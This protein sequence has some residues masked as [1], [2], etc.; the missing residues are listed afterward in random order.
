MKETREFLKKEILTPV[1]ALVETL[2]WMVKTATLQSLRMVLWSA[3]YFL[4]L[5]GGFLFAFHLVTAKIRRDAE[6]LK[7][8]QVSM[9]TVSAPS[10][11]LGS[12]PTRPT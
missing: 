12:A 9:P 10:R 7:P 4:P 11:Y 1:R 8:S 6:S 3:L 2:K 5:I